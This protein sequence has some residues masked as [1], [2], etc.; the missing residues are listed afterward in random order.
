MD[1]LFQTITQAKY[2]PNEQRQVKDMNIKEIPTYVAANL[3][4]VLPDKFKNIKSIENILNE[5]LDLL[6]S[7]PLCMSEQQKPK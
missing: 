3:L 5:T 6:K 7:M 2:Y 4:H 1:S